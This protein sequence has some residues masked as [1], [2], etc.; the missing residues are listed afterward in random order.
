M[1]SLLPAQQE[2]SVV[3]LLITLAETPSKSAQRSYILAS[4]TDARNLSLN[5]RKAGS[6][7]QVLVNEKSVF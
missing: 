1:P 5:L 4:R 7:T 6:Y 2:C 3:E